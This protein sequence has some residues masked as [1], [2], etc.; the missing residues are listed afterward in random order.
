MNSRIG[1]TAIIV[2]FLGAVLISCQR[3]TALEGVWIGCEL[4]KPCIDW[5]LTIEGNRFQLTR[6]DSLKWYNGSFQLNN[7][8]AL[9]K[10]DLKINDAHAPS[11]KGRTILGIY[12]IG[13][14]SLTVVVGQPGHPARPLSL[15]DQ[16][17]AIVFNFD[18]S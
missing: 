10:I 12:Q 11:Q 18:R 15:E 13:S 7:N 1:N 17:S 8:C 6:D 9:N 5:S 4:R 16:E 2:C 14:S 3:P